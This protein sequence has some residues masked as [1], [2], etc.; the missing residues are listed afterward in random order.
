MTDKGI[1]NYG[2][3]GTS[4]RRESVEEYFGWKREERQESEKKPQKP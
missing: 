4:P 1:W 2:T 3:L